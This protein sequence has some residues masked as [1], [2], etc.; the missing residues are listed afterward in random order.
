M[1]TEDERTITV[2]DVRRVAMSLARTEEALVR[3]HV[4]FRVRGIVYASISPDETLMGFGFPKEERAALVASEPEKF[5]MPLP[6]DERYQ[7][8]RARLSALGH[9]EMRE[10]VTDAWRM[11]VPKFLIRAHDERQA[12]P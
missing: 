6:S 4:K 7:W 8:V 10:L 12:R 11:V 1:T 3:D 9:D 2:E 5:L